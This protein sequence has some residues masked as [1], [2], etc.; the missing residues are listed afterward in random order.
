LAEEEISF[1]RLRERC[2]VMA[3]RSDRE[4]G[5]PTACPRR[6]SLQSRMGPCSR[7]PSGPA[8]PIDCINRPD[9]RLHP[10]NA[11]TSFYLLQCGSHPQRTSADHSEFSW[12]HALATRLPCRPVQLR[13]M[14]AAEWDCNSSV[15][16]RLSPRDCAKRNGGHRRGRPPLLPFGRRKGCAWCHWRRASLKRRLTSSRSAG[17]RLFAFG[18][19]RH[20]ARQAPTL[21]VQ[22]ASGV[23]DYEG[24]LQ[25]VRGGLP[26]VPWRDRSKRFC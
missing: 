7:T 15:T 12:G 20:P 22:P 24:F 17:V 2:D 13:M 5:Q 11:N 14:S 18:Q 3:N 9:R 4:Q 8:V 21:P 16:L 1:T 25:Q 26:V 19:S 10:T 23:Q 6:Q